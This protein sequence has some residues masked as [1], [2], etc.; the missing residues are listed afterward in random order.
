MDSTRHSIDLVHRKRLR[1]VELGTEGNTLALCKGAVIADNAVRRTVL[2]ETHIQ[3]RDPGDGFCKVSFQAIQIACFG[4][5]GDLIQLVAH[6]VPRLPGFFNGG[7]QAFIA[8]LLHGKKLVFLLQSRI[9]VK[10][11]CHQQEDRI[12]QEHQEQK[13]DAHNDVDLQAPAL[14]GALSG[15]AGL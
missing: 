5:R 13:R 3:I 9:P 8:L 1:Q 15:S 7:F 4:Q 12:E 11:V 2:A 6:I 14:S 10:A